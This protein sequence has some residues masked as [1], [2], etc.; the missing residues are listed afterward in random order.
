MRNR[1]QENVMDTV[2][3]DLE[4]E[5]HDIT[6]FDNPYHREPTVQVIYIRDEPEHRMLAGARSEIFFDRQPY[7]NGH[8]RSIRETRRSQKR[9]H[10]R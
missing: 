5:A 3:F 2:V 8:P 4:C 1:Q 7:Y 6:H 9:G 10:K